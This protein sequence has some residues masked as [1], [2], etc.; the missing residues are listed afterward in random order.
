MSAMPKQEVGHV[1]TH[2][3]SLLSDLHK[4]VKDFAKQN[5]EI[6]GRTRL[7]A[8]NATIEA[9]RAG[10]AGR[11]FSVVAHEVKQLAEQTSRTAV[12][13]EGAVL[14][15]VET[16]MEVSLEMTEARLSSMAHAQVQQIVRNLYERTADV[17]WWATDTAVWEALGV[18]AAESVRTHAARRL[19]VIHRYYTVYSDL[20][21][22]DARGR[23][24]ATASGNAQLKDCSSAD[25]FIKAMNT[26]NGDEYVVDRVQR[27][28]A[29][30]N[31][32]VLTYAAAVRPGGERLGKPL[33]VLGV[34]FDWEKQ[35]KAT[36]KDELTLSD[37]EW[38]RTRVLLL[39]SSGIC[40]ASSDNRGVLEPFQLDHGGQKMGV[41]KADG[42]VVAF[43][44]TTGYQEYDGLGWYGV[45]VQDQ[46]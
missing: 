25:W 33:G 32:H 2:L 13:F 41:Y 45:V 18:N 17:R 46:K 14:T 26:A 3:P 10:E 5:Q 7:L 34:M 38:S 27:S 29:H 35:S 20:I 42:R 30:N 22:T 21:L 28:P 1:A 43:A 11:G 23:V 39:D 36:V 44:R 37:D 8:L 16:G 12:S 15:G 31:H 9:A 19:G 6:A 4:R 40:I 24:V